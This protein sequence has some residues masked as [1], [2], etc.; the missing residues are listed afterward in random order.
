M[1]ECL[2]TRRAL[3][4]PRLAALLLLLASAQAARAAWRAAGDVKSVERLRGGVVLTLTSGAS[5]SV[6]CAPYYGLGDKADSTH[7]IDTQ[8]FVMWTTDTHAYPRGL[9][10]IYQAIGFFIALRNEQGRALAYDHF[11]DNTPRTYFDMRKTDPA[12]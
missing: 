7:S 12:R 2:R 9:D 1:N 5:V 4:L 8:L 10:P 6:A 3:L 11:L